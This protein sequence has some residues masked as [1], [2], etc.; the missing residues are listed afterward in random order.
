MLMRGRH[1]QLGQWQE[2]PLLLDICTSHSFFLEHADS[3]I[4]PD[5]PTTLFP[6]HVSLFYFIS[7][8]FFSAFFFIVFY[9]VLSASYVLCVFNWIFIFA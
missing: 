3:T 9:V 6:R 7:F 5:M 8:L 2:D 1:R 4:P